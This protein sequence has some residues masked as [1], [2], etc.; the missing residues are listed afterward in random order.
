MQLFS[1]MQTH[2]HTQTLRHK[3]T[4]YIECALERPYGFGHTRDEHNTISI[5]CT[6]GSI[7]IA[8]RWSVLS[9]VYTRFAQNTLHSYTFIDTHQ[10]KL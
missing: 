2:T 3:Y 4:N 7:R 8:I 6:I 9:K 10:L 1:H 5:D